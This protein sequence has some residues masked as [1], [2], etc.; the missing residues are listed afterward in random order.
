MTQGMYPPRILDASALV[1]VFSGNPTMMQTLD[2]AD[3]GQLVAVMPVLAMA[4]AQ[5]VLDA[6][7]SHWSHILALPGVRSMPLAEDAA[8][9]VGRIAGPR[10]RH[11]PVHTALIGPLMTAQVLHEAKTMNAVTMTRFPEAYGGHQVAI[12][13]IE[14]SW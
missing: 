8:I 2:D 10:V 5:V 4:E 3:A 9:E 1:E 12:Y 14:A 6:Q 11:H 7:D 13:T